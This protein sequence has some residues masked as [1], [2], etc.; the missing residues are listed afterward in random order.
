MAWRLCFVMVISRPLV[1]MFDLFPVIAIRGIVFLFK[2]CNWITYCRQLLIRGPCGSTHN[3]SI[4]N[5]KYTIYMSVQKNSVDFY[6]V[7]G[8][9]ICNGH[10]LHYWPL[11]PMISWKWFS[12]LWCSNICCVILNMM[13]IYINFDNNM[14]IYNTMC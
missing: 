3:S 4:F 2:C 7:D 9:Y 1:N 10:G 5:L 6:N 11:K 13:Y 12:Y 8:M 14:L